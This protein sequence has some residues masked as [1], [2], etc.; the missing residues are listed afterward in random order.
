MSMKYNIM[1][2]SIMSANRNEIMIIMKCNNINVMYN[3]V[4]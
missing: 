3:G 2:M 1:K 4:Q